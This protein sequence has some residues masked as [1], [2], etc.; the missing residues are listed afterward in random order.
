MNVSWREKEITITDDSPKNRPKNFP[1]IVFL[2]GSQISEL[3]PSNLPPSKDVNFQIL[4]HY[5]HPK[6]HAKIEEMEVCPTHILITLIKEYVDPEAEIL[7]YFER[8]HAPNHLHRFLASQI[9]QKNTVCALNFDYLIEE[10]LKEN[11]HD[12]KA[13]YPIITDLDYSDFEDPFEI[14]HNRYFPIYKLLGSRLNIITGDLTLDSLGTVE[15]SY[16]NATIIPQR[17]KIPAKRINLVQKL[18]EE[19]IVVLLGFTEQD[20]PLLRDFLANAQDIRKIY[21]IQHNP[22]LASKDPFIIH[23]LFHPERLTQE[24]Q[25]LDVA[26]RVTVTDTKYKTKNGTKNET[27]LIPTLTDFLH[28]LG[29]MN[30]CDVEI[31]E[32]NLNYFG[33]QSLFQ[34]SNIQIS[35]PPVIQSGNKSIPLPEWIET[36]EIPFPHQQF[37]FT[38]YL[39]ETMQQYDL[40]LQCASDGYYYEDGEENPMFRAL[41][42]ANFANMI[43][44]LYRLQNDLPSA[45]EFL[46]NA[47]KYTQQVD[48]RFSE[49]IILNSIGLLHFELGHHEEAESYLLDAL[50][51]SKETNNFANL[52][53]VLSH[54]GQLAQDKE[55]YLEALE[56]YQEVYTLD[57]K[58]DNL[59]GQA[60]DLSN[61]G[62][63]HELMGNYQEALECI[64]DALEIDLELGDL[65]SSISRINNI[66]TIYC[67]IEDF[68]NAKIYYEKAIELAKNLKIIPLEVISL[69]NLGLLYHNFEKYDDAIQLFQQCLHLDEIT[70]DLGD[71]SIHLNNLGLVYESLGQYSEAIEY[72]AES[73]QMDQNN[74]RYEG[75]ATSY[76]NIALSYYHQ[77]N[78][79]QAI[80]FF[81]KAINFLKKNQMHQFLPAFEKEL[82]TIRKEL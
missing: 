61:L 8:G 73:N 77:E 75:V 36:L 5:S 57:V 81:E 27:N 10:A 51:I 82:D 16:M 13:I 30:E 74:Q 47:L 68:T 26:K 60:I 35:N 48:N 32:D 46:E 18:I 59:H 80:I 71:K 65:V 12:F 22:N 34:Q 72:F 1:E 45:L 56:Y 4:K 31:I 28:T 25:D 3:S 21:F 52:S 7:G 23:S 50:Q 33:S 41:R 78:I 11:V 49:G 37:M 70:E 43:G 62:V 39:F 20:T 69:N 15:T 42:K 38:T 40:A 19:R 66:G 53:A 54:L 58:T 17:I 64:N 55:R 24:M 9:L 44:L 14:N 6:Y 2:V 79:P 29:R 67:D 63:I 76:R